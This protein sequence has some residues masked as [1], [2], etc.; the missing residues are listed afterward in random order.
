MAKTRI[1]WAGFCNNVI[2]KEWLDLGYAAVGFFV[3]AIYRLKKNALR[4]YQDVRPVK[5]ILIKT[6]TKGGK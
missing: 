6:K 1:Y 2:G 4:R 5:I 3:P